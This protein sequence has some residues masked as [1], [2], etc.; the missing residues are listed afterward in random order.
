ML[1]YGIPQRVMGSGMDL[2]GEGICP[3]GLKCSC[4]CCKY[5]LGDQKDVWIYP[6]CSPVK[7]YIRGVKIGSIERKGLD[8][9]YDKTNTGIRYIKDAYYVS[10][11]GKR[12]NIQDIYNGLVVDPDFPVPTDVKSN[13]PVSRK[14][15]QVYLM[16]DDCVFCS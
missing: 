8:I 12:Y 2:I 13:E 1:I 14:K 5:E 9:V 11:S 4:G 7:Y 6:C 16:L 15:P 10:S 3:A